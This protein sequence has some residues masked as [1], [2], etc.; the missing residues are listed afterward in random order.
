MRRLTGLDGVTLH[1]ETAVMPTHVMAVLF[2]DPAA[3]GELTAGAVLR[4]LAQRTAATPGFRQRL[5]TKPFGLGQPVWIE[6][7][8]FNVE[9]HLHRVRLPKPGTMPELDALLGEL[10]GQRLHR[11]RPLW[12]AWVVQGLADGRL[13]VVIKFAHAMSDGVRAVTSVLPRLMTTDPDAEFPATPG[14]GAARMPV[15]AAI[16]LD[17]VDEIAANTAVGVRIAVRV[18]PSAVKS[19]LG[20]ALRPVRQLLGGD[21][22]QRLDA[23]KSDMDGSSPRTLLNAPITA[24]RSVTFAAL[25]MDDLRAITEAFDVTINDVFLTATTS[26]LRRWLQVHDTVPERPL[27]TLM[28]ISTRGA[29]DDATNSWSPAVVKLP[30]HLADP[31]EQLVSIRAATSQIKNRRQAAP[32]VNLADVIDL[33]PP[34]IIG[35]MAGLYT[36][37]KLSRFHPPLAHVITSNV[38]GPPDE[39]YCAGSRVLGIHALAPLCEGANLN[40]TAVSYGG[41]FAVGIVACPDNVDDVAS[42]ARG[43]ED[44]VGEL[45]Q[46]ADEK[47]GRSAGMSGI[48]PSASATK[49]TATT[50]FAPP[51]KQ[52]SGKKLTPSTKRPA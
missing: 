30:V 52:A 27:R 5:L 2:C 4:L 33:V 29:G 20:T 37:L 25:A 7:P 41:T 10:H 9:H 40:I 36:G 16:V 50:Q 23:P 22:P 21:G 8:A 34:V 51:K 45:K 47:S 48:K 35:Q 42:V 24:R 26:A 44:V 3:R 31:V 11:D 12:E 1:G 18:A 6:D 49:S 13:V 14:P 15:A 43:I 32:P 38:P 28:P 46:A 19:V 17:I 39:I